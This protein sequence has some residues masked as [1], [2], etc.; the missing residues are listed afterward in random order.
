[1]ILETLEFVSGIDILMLAV[2][3][4]SVALGVFA[5]VMG[6]KS[7]RTATEM[8]DAAL[9]MNKD[10][11]EINRDTHQ[12]TLLAEQFAMHP[13]EMELLGKQKEAGTATHATLEKDGWGDQKPFRYTY[14][15]IAS[16]MRDLDKHRIPSHTVIIDEL[17][18]FLSNEGQASKSIP[19]D[20]SIGD[21]PYA[22]LQL[23]TALAKHG[24]R[25]ALF[26]AEESAVSG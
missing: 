18:G 15:D 20:A 4:V 25:L 24:I 26:P 21:S 9:L 2:G 5:I 1:M 14:E 11:Q 8:H 16:V 23:R 7:E 19:I 10:T 3:L 13:Y 12:M 22:L 6:K 17:P